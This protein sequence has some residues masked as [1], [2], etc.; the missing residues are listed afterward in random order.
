MLFTPSHNLLSWTL[1]VVYGPCRQPARD[2]FINWLHNLAIDDEDFWLL[3]GDFNF[4]RFADNRNKPGGNYNDF[5][6]FNNISSHLGLIELPIKGRSYTWSNMHDSPLLEQ[7]DW[8]FS[9][10]AWTS[11]F[12]MTVVL[13][14]IEL[15]QIICHAKSKLAQTFPKPISL[16]SKITGSATLVV[17]IISKMPGLL[18]FQLII[19]PCD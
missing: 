11:Q 14:L 12:P 15:L 6:V 18:Q 17:W 16:D 13:P 19:V 2:N 8:F 4:Y 10:V 3:M 9:S 7:L 5:L 1:V